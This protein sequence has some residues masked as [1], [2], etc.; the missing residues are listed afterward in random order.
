MGFQDVA[1]LPNR[2]SLYKTCEMSTRREHP[3]EWCLFSAMS[4]SEEIALKN[5]PMS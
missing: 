3:D 5:Q 4:F 2:A 1:F